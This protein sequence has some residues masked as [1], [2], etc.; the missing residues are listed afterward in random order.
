MRPFFLFS[1]LP[2]AETWAKQHAAGPFCGYVNNQPGPVGRFEMR[3]YDC[4]HGRLWLAGHQGFMGG[5]PRYTPEEMM[6]N[7]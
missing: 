5:V 6:A 2:N 4:L 1:N 3:K 7:A